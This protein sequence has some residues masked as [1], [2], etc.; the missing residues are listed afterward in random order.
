MTTKQVLKEFKEEFN[1]RIEH[2]FPH[3]LNVKD[4]LLWSMIYQAMRFAELLCM[5]NVSKHLY[6][7]Y[8]EMYID[9]NKNIQS[10]TYLKPKE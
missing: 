1:K 8:K 7:A 10:P 6:M 2:E 5:L 9:L 4:K 3:K